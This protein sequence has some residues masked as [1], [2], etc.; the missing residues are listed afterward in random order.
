MIKT[1]L[2]F[3]FLSVILLS[4]YFAEAAITPL[5]LTI[6][7]PVQFPAEDFS[8]TGLRLG[9]LGHHRDLFG[10]DL[11]LIGNITDQE[12]RGL[13]LSGIFNYTKGD[14]TIFG[15]QLAGIANVNTSKIN[16]YGLQ[17]A[18]GANY[19]PATSSVVG[20][21][22]ALANLS[23][24]TDIYGLQLG[25]YNKSASVHGLQIGLVNVTNNLHGV[26]I[27]IVN[28]NA[29]GPFLVSPI[30]NVGF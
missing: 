18:L 1:G 20:V 14:S 3:F 4:S 26:Q 15:I 9:L 30:L 16:V 24:F 8:I 23:A 5:A 17:F 11:G 2:K 28:F 6:V 13:A 19:N 21:Q 25:V 12:F 7:P 27:G 10:V 29:K 22:I